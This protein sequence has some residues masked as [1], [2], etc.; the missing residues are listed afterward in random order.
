MAAL[1]VLLS[2]TC[3]CELGII[4]KGMWK[5]GE[6]HM[7]LTDEEQVELDRFLLKYR[8]HEKIQEMRRYIQHG[9]ITTYD[10]A[11]RVT[12]LCFLLNRRWHLGADERALV[13]GA[14]MHDFYLYDWHVN[15]KSHRLH[16]YH[17]P[18]TSCENA[19]RYF[20]VDAQV[21]QMIRSHMWPLTITHVPGSRE[22]WILCLADKYIS[23]SETLLCRHAKH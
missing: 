16:G 20:H 7:K 23:L 22:A 11:E 19:I 9:A 1:F 18:D 13:L 8:G 2:L 5:A 3:R 6:S 4:R 17:H 15:D 21:Q 14:F 10:H 12:A